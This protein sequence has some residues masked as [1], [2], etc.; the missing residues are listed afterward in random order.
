LENKLAKR[1]PHESSVKKE[2]VISR[3]YKGD[4]DWEEITEEEFLRRTEWAGL[5]KHGEALN[6]LKKTKTLKTEYA[7]YTIEAWAF[8][9]E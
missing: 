5:F 7:D 1:L 8:P 4:K 6:L 2:I 9:V 3:K